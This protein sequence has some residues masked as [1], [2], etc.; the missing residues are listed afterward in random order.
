M[1]VTIHRKAHFNSAHRLYRKDWSDEKN[2]QVFG[3]CAYPNYHGHNYDLI[4]SVTGEVDEN[5]G[6]VM[7]LDDLKQI[8]KYEVEDYLDHRNLNLDI[9]EF[10]D[11]IPTV[12]NI[13]VL[14]WNKIREKIDKD[15][16]LEVTLYETERN[17]VTY[18][19]N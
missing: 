10:F 14:I 15:K 4:V 2:L 8:I 13:A 3:K 7:N 18:K 16:K 19:G 17:Y 11:K 1:E 6:F 5:T 9:P 12:E